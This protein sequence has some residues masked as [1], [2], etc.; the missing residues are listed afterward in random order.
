[1]RYNGYLVDLDG[2]IYR[3]KEIIP[4]GKRFVETLQKRTF[5]FYL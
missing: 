3:G 5:P 2:T 4:A 1:M